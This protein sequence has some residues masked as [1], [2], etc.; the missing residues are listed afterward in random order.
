[1]LSIHSLKRGL[2]VLCEHQPVVGQQ[3]GN[4]CHCCYAIGSSNSSHELVFSGLIPRV[5]H[6]LAATHCLLVPV[7]EWKTHNQFMKW[8]WFLFFIS[9]SQG[10]RD[11]F[12]KSYIELSFVLYSP[13]SLKWCTETFSKI[14][15]TSLLF[16]QE[17]KCVMFDFSLPLLTWIQINIKPKIKKGSSLLIMIISQVTE[18]PFLISK[19]EVLVC[20][21]FCDR[22]KGFLLTSFQCLSYGVLQLNI[23]LA[24][25]SFAHPISITA[26]AQLHRSHWP[27]SERVQ[28]SQAQPLGP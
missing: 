25:S 7:T 18:K 19:S 28:R 27:R 13:M 20:M 10:G 4:V 5:K 15:S 17:V 6:P 14:L 26:P 12:W 23:P 24:R 21:C 22:R 8:D 1:M 2:E 11:T 16:Q 3:L 9:T